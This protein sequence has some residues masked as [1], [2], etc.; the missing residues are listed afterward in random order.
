MDPY[1]A[2]EGLR[3][4][5]RSWKKKL[6]GFE[7]FKGNPEQICESIIERCWNGQYFETSIGHFKQY[8]T[9]DTAMVAEALNKLGHKKRIA[10]SLKYALPKFK[11]ANR[12][13]TMISPKGRVLDFPGYTP[14]S[15]A[16]T[17]RLLKFSE[18]EQLIKEFKPFLENEALKTL[19]FAVDKNSGLLRKDKNFSTMKDNAK[20]VSP[21]Y[22]NCMLGMTSKLLTELKLDNPLKQFNYPSLIKDTFWTG[23]YFLDD[24]SGKTYVSGDANTFPFWTGLFKDKS[25]FNVAV[26]SIQNEYLDRLY[27]L[28]YT[29][30]P[31][32]GQYL[33]VQNVF[34]PNYEGNT[35]WLHLGVCFLENLYKFNHPVL[36]EQ[37]EK[38]DE[39]IT[40]Y[41]T[42]PEVLN[43][44]G[45]PYKSPFYYCDEGMLWSAA[46]LNVK[47]NKK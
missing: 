38:Y 24:L 37:L 12:I 45:S 1:L 2:F 18:D 11:K 19:N 20:R 13:G 28:R 7:K 17:L 21:C 41:K 32:K 16:Y 8:W 43:P 15:L 34:T 6:Y 30:H 4:Y 27:A 9:R 46:Y 25:M 40:R 22:T 23:T 5:A 47:K 31:I 26:E 42:F 36:K 35:I 3:I 39:L 29:Q 14:E 10:A 33:W 44:D